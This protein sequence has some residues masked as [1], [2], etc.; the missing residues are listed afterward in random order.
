M[1]LKISNLEDWNLVIIALT[2]NVIDLLSMKTFDIAMKV[3]LLR[4]ARILLH[5]IQ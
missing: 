1:E 2:V 3:F 5:T 4:A